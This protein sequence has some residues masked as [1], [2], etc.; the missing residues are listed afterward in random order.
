M[1]DNITYARPCEQPEMILLY[2]KGANPRQVWEV[3]EVDVRQT[4]DVCGGAEVARAAEPGG[5]TTEAEL[6]GGELDRVDEPG[7]CNAEPG[8]DPPCYAQGVHIQEA[9]YCLNKFWW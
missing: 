5:C 2:A 4:A 7:G 3:G 8:A 9:E 6:C 1:R